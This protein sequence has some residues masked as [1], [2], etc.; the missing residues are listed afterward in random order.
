MDWDAAAPPRHRCTGWLAVLIV[1]GALLAVAAV[2]CVAFLGLVYFSF[3]FGDDDLGPH[4]IDSQ[5]AARAMHTRGIG[6]PDGFVFGEMTELREFVGANDYWGRYLAPSDFAAAE[7]AVTEVNPDFPRLRKA[8][9]ADEI[10]GTNFPDMPGFTCGAST[11]LAVST[12]ARPG[13]DVLIDNYHG[14]PPDAET[15][16][17]V[18]NEDRVELFVLSAGH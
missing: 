11:V 4:P 9:C 6:I 18:G 17:L 1:L 3:S 10:V 7:R 8:T 16:L 12:R 15:L 2:G 5:A 14:T 13:E